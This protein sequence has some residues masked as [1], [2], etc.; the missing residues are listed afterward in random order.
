MLVFSKNHDELIRA[1]RNFDNEKM[2]ALFI[3]PYRDYPEHICLPNE[4]TCHDVMLVLKGCT[5]HLEVTYN[6]DY[7]IHIIS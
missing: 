7:I 3:K 6:S 4:I 1:Q 5:V 2:G